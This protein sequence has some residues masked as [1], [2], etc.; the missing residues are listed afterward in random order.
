MLRPRNA[1]ATVFKPTIKAVAA[2]L[3]ELDVVGH[4]SVAAPVLGSYEPVA[5]PMEASTIEFGSATPAATAASSHVEKCSSGSSPST[6]SP[7]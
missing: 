6:P 2:P 3:P 1:G 7:A 4:E 5:A